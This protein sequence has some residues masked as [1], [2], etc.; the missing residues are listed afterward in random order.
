[1]EGT[2]SVGV[3]EGFLSSVKAG[4]GSTA[5]AN[6]EFPCAAG[7]PKSREGLANAVRHTRASSANPGKPQHA[8]RLHFPQL[9]S[10][11]DEFIADT[12]KGGWQQASPSSVS[13]TCDKVRRPKEKSVETR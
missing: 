8:F 9:C 1:M 7:T 4:E 12:V 3:K 2:A 13:F 6:V 11:T 10:P 5:A